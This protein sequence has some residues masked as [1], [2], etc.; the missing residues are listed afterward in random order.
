MD[1]QDFKKEINAK[2]IKRKDNW[3]T[4]T[5]HVLGMRVEL[6]AYNTWLQ[7]YTVDGIEYGGMADK[8]VA[9][10]NNVLEEPFEGMI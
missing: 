6:K 4:W 1:F 9:Y 3:Y 2:R 8:S 7:R 10:F 5:G